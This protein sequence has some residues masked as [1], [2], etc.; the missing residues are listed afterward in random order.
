MIPIAGAGRPGRVHGA[1]AAIEQRFDRGIGMGGAAGIVRVVDHA[2]DAGIDAAHGGEV[3]ADIV[4]L[5]PIEFGER[6]MRGVHVVR[7]RRRIGIDAAQ[8]SFPGMAVA[9]DQAG[10]D[11]GIERID[12]LRIRSID[13]GRDRGNLAAFDQEIAFHQ[14]ADLGVHADDGAAFEQ[15]AALRIDVLLMIEAT[16]VVRRCGFG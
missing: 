11:D 1:D 2:S 7:K 15:D 10:H 9:I 12:H 6:Q 3:I 13:L 14:V 4:I 5:R 8:L 16:H